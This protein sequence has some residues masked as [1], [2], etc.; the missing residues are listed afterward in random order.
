[1]ESFSVR[2]N[3]LVAAFLLT[4]GSPAEAQDSLH[5]S[6]GGI[7]IYYGILPAELVLGHEMEHGGSKAARGAHHLIVAVFNSATGKRVTDAEVEATVEP[8][9]LA[10]ETKKLEPMTINQT[11]TYGNYFRMPDLVPYRIT[12]RVR[13]PGVEDWIETKFEYRH[14]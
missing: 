13:P 11:V 5:S 12:I 4:A 6:A 1:M 2:L 7:E 9:G 10:V 14:Q 8:L 3:T